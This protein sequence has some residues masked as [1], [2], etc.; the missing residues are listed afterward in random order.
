MPKNKAGGKKFRGKKKDS[1]NGTN[2]EIER[3]L[4]LKEDGQEY[5]RVSKMLGNRRILAKTNQGDEV[6]CIIPGKFKSRVW[7]DVNDIILI[8]IRDYQSD[9]SDVIY[10]YFPKEIK[11]LN[12]LG[13]LSNHISE[14]IDLFSDKANTK[15]IFFEEDSE[16]DNQD[17]EL[18]EE[19]NLED[20]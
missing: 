11:E 7:I 4:E 13:Q 1:K 10:K 9:K 18:S 19:I 16:S 8:S 2:G 5:A 20:L 17:K 14:N 15:D 3:K 12:K 6:L